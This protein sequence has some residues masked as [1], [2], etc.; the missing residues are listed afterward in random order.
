MAPHHSPNGG[1]NDASMVD[2]PDHSRLDEM[3]RSLLTRAD[4]ALAAGYAVC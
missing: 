2:A 4:V 3:V 1:D